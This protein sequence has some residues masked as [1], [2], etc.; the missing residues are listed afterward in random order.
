MKTLKLFLTLALTA[1]VTTASAQF[2]N[3]GASNASSKSH[4]GK[5][6]LEKDTES[7]N[8]IYVSYS[9]L[10]L[11]GFYGAAGKLSLT[12]V[13]AGYTH[14]I[15]LKSDLPLFLEI[16][17]QVSYASGKFDKSDLPLLSLLDN[18]IDDDPMFLL[19]LEQKHT[20]V[21]VSVPVAVSYKLSFADKKFSVAPLIGLNFRYN[22][23]GEFETTINNSMLDTIE[24]GFSN[25]IYK[26]W[27]NSP[28]DQMLYGPREGDYKGFQI[29]W[30]IGLNINYKKLNLGVSYTKDFSKITDTAKASITYVTLGVNF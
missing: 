13:S 29:G 22:I 24:P 1:A 4:S 2:A 25:E 5:S 6:V 9:P 20:F 28:S 23:I 7:Y 10:A 19:N 11:K 3:T 18:M 16:G 21:A 26:I 30:Q 14:G 8:R 15:N 12:G 17:G 27:D